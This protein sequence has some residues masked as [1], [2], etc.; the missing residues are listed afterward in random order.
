VAIPTS[1]SEYF[2]LCDSSSNKQ[3]LKFMK[4]QAVSC[5]QV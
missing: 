4:L 3:M 1:R 2:I 5:E